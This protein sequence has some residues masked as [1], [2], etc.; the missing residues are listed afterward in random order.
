M[1]SKLAG[2]V[3][4]KATISRIGVTGL[5]AG[6]VMVLLLPLAAHAQGRPSGGGTSSGSAGAGSR[7]V[8]GGFSSGASSGSYSAPSRNVGGSYASAP[9]RGISTGGMPRILPGS[10]FTNYNY[11]PF[12][13]FS[14]WLW[15][16]YNWFELMQ[17]GLW[18]MHRF[19][20]NREPLI[21]PQ[22]LHLT[23]STPLA[24][25]ERLLA[26]VDALQALVDDK[27]AGK[28]V[29]KEQ[30]SAK[31]Q[32]IRD[33]AKRI[34]SYQPLAFFDLGK[35]QDVAKGV[36]K[37]GLGAISQLREMALDMNSQL[38]S[39]YNQTATST[40]S[41]NSLNQASFQSLS[42]GIEKLSKVIENAK[43]RS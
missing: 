26:E 20:V 38:K 32:E 15:T 36:D 24:A 17:F 10:S 30:I 31:T 13:N 33:L 29:T 6:M 16:N 37:L 4:M 1:R 34:R 14:N 22:M 39:M 3:I 7:G 21:T 25:S 18:D 40:V 12:M 41:V 9:V 8:G 28:P 27:Q 23:L 11:Y 19:Y 42:K 5:V 35:K 2:G 43:P